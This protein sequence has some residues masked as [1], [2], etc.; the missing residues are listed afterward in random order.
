[1]LTM[2]SFYRET[3]LREKNPFFF[4]PVPFLHVMYTCTFCVSLHVKVETL[5][6]GK[7]KRLF[8]Y[9]MNVIL[10]AV[11]ISDNL[12]CFRLLGGYWKNLHD[13]KL[14]CLLVCLTPRSIASPGRHVH[15]YPVHMGPSSRH[16]RK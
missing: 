13:F 8:N 2:D 6:Q 3:I 10:P 11:S 1:M 16:G 4:S 5:W 9:I 14:F 15:S 7:E 12:L